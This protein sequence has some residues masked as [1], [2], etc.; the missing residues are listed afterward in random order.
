MGSYNEVEGD[1]IKLAK[2]GTFD[3]ITHGV[4]CFCN[5]ASGIAPQMARAFGA[6]V[7]PLEDQD[8]RGDMNKLGQIDYKMLYITPSG[9][10]AG[11]ALKMRRPEDA[12]LLAVVNS[13]SQ[14]QPRV[15]IKPLDYEALTLCL[16]KINAKFAGNH[17]GLPKIGAGLAGGD[18]DRIKI[19]IQQEL[20]DCEVTVVIY[21]P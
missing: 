17:I 4:N 14:Y 2:Q 7:F 16:R 9:L 18:W 3:V 1:L 19:I 21:K 20:K 8:T 11:D 12:K 10:V 6:N 15:D 13:Y 5:M